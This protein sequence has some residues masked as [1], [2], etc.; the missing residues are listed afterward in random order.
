[1]A[2]NLWNKFFITNWDNIPSYEPKSG[3]VEAKDLPIASNWRQYYEN[4]GYGGF[5]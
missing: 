1:M 3:I 4:S 5:H 2:Q